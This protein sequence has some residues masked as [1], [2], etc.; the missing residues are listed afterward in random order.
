MNGMVA[1]QDCF[2]FIE[3]KPIAA[4]LDL[5]V[6]ASEIVEAPHSIL[7]HNVPSAIKP[8]LTPLDQGTLRQVRASPVATHHGGAGDQQLVVL[9]HGGVSRA[10]ASN[11]DGTA[12][13]WEL[14]HMEARTDVR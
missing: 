5:P 13:Q 9:D 3:F 10:C 1:Q 14:V 2:D 4:N 11:R 6:L 12:G 8:L 7:P